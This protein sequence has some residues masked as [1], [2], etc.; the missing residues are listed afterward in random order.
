M[1]IL[2]LSYLVIYSTKHVCKRDGAKTAQAPTANSWCPFPGLFPGTTAHSAQTGRIG[3]APE[4]PVLP[5]CF[6][7][8]A[9]DCAEKREI[10]DGSRSETQSGKS[11]ERAKWMCVLQP[12]RLSN[13]GV[14]PLSCIMEP[15]MYPF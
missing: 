9:T 1:T 10:R 2:L 8:L 6:L 12:A 5:N 11:I 15:G 4:S 13:Y 14:G 3:V 7:V